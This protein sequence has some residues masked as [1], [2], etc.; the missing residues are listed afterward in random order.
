MHVGNDHTMGTGPRHFTP[1]SMVADNDLAVGRLVD[2]VSHSRFWSSTAIS[3]WKTTRK[4][5][6][7]T[8][9][10]TVPFCLSFHPSRGFT[11]SNM[12]VLHGFGPQDDRTNPRPSQPHLLDDRAPS[13]LVDFEEQPSLEPYTPVKPAVPLD[14]RNPHNA[15]GAKQSARWD[16]TRPDS[17]PEEE[18][19][20]VIWKSV[21]GRNSEPP[22]SVFNVQARMDGRPG[23]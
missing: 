2:L 19:N 17:A 18:L 1:R 7:T 21:K 11:R 3:S 8:S 13:L 22:A 23:S 6:L 16:F 15:P 14:E 9:M 12:L 4:M 20:R 5:V 10:P